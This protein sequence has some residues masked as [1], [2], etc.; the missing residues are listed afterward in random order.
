MFCLT[1]N[2]YNLLIAEN[3]TGISQLKEKVTFFAGKL[4]L[5]QL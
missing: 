2:I 1:V 3:T 4:S 5:V